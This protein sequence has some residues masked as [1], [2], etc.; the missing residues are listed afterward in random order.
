MIHFLKDAT[1][2]AL[3]PV[4]DTEVAKF[5]WLSDINTKEI[6][7]AF[8]GQYPSVLT[9][10]VGPAIV[11][12]LI[13]AECAAPVRVLSRAQAKDR[14][15]YLARAKAKGG[16]YGAAW[17]DPNLCLDCKKLGQKK[18]AAK[19]E[20]E[21]EQQTE[22]KRALRT[23]PYREFL[24]TPE[25][26]ATRKAALKRAGYRCQTCAKAGQMHVHHRTYVNR[27]AERPADLIVLCAD[28]HDLFHKN[29]KLSS[30]GRAD[31]SVIEQLSRGEYLQ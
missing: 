30:G 7:A 23:M 4:N 24:Q 12:G 5:Y 15:D 26:Q 20:G 27:G 11:S 3:E 19:W 14:I 22:R 9:T 29:G 8:K 2:W 25:W 21:R 10:F 18:Q 17:A 16:W 1:E 13:C 6:A 28:C 31:T